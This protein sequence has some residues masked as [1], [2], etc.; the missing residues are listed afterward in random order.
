MYS[1]G[2]LCLPEDI[3]YAHD[4]LGLRVAAVVNNSS[5]GFYPDEASVLSQ[6]AILT[7]HRLTLGTHC[8][9]RQTEGGKSCQRVVLL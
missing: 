2:L 1:L 7:T 4:A 5:L 9:E 6:H 3:V 8:R